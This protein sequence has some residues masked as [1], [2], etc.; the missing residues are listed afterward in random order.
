MRQSNRRVV[1]L[2]TALLYLHP[3]AV[4]W[5]QTSG[6]QEESGDARQDAGWAVHWLNSRLSLLMEEGLITRIK[7]SSSGD[8]YTVYVSSGWQNFPVGEK[9]AFLRDFSRARALTGHSPYMVL[10]MNGSEQMI[11]EVNKEG[12]FIYG[13]QHSFSPRNP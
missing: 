8:S 10:K 3:A 9:E 5:A 1:L 13:D 6:A 12:V 7:P 4:S 2:L 11:A